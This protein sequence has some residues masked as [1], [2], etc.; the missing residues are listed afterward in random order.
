M[1]ELFECQGDL[2][3]YYKRFNL[4]LKYLGEVE[5]NRG[6]RMIRNLQVYSITPENINI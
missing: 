6:N 1:C 2:V 5:I 3:D 4:P